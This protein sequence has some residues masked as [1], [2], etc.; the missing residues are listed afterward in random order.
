MLSTAAMGLAPGF[1]RAQS[2]S[3]SDSQR[4]KTLESTVADLEKRV[5]AIESELKPEPEPEPDT[6]AAVLA[7]RRRLSAR[8]RRD[9]T[10]GLWD[11]ATAA[12]SSRT[13]GPG[14]RNA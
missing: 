12:V 5:A 10:T 1:L 4:I 11:K 9:S 14:V 2:A 13:R 7:E 3:D 6:E 8:V